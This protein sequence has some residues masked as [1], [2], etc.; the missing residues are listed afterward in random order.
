MPFPKEKMDLK[1]YSYVDPD[2][3][4][5]M[6]HKLVPLVNITIIARHTTPGIRYRFYIEHFAILDG[7]LLIPGWKFQPITWKIWVRR[8]GWHPIYEME[9]DPVMFETNNQMIKKKHD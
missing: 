2:T 3:K 6:A 8:K 4:N 7:I 5:G 9:N 1:F